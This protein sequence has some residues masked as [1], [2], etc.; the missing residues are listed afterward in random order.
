MLRVRVLGD[1]ELEVDGRPVEPPPSRRARAL[2]GYLAL[3]PGTHPRSVLAARFWPDVLDESARTSLRGALTALRR[4][5]GPAA[6]AH[7][8]ATREAAG[9]ADVWTDAAAFAALVA[10]GRDAEA[11]ALCRGELLAG[12]DDD[13]VLAARDQHR[14]AQ[15]AALARL[16]EAAGDP[17]EALRHARAR[18]ALDPLSEE[19]HR[20]LMA[21]LAASGDRAAALAAYNRLAE[22]LRTELR[23]A[24]SAATREAAE[25][26]RRAEADRPPFPGAVDPTGARSPF[27]GRREPLDRLRAAVASGDRHLLAVSG[28]PGI[29]KT[30]LL[31][32]LARGAYAD[33]AAV[34]YGRCPEEPVAPYQAFAEAL[35]PLAAAEPGIAPL[36]GEGG[37]EP[38]DAAGARLRLFEA[39]AAA[40][41]GTPGPVLLALDDLHWADRPS[42][43]LLSHLLRDPRPARLVV[44]GTYRESELGRGHPLARALADLRRDRLVDRVALGGLDDA[45]A[46]RLIEAWVGA[47]ATADLVTAVH[48]ETGGN[49][50][51]IE[52]VLRHLL[53]CGAVEGGH[54]TRS[55]SELGVPESVREVIGRRLDRLGGEAVEV[56][57]TAAVVGPEFELA[58]LERAGP[59]RE[60]VL[61]ALERAADANLIRDGAASWSFTHALIREALHGGL[62][63]L[64]RA[65]L[66]ARVAEALAELG[67]DPGRLAHHGLEAAG[68]IG[69]ERAA[70]WAAAAGDGAL[71]ALAYEEA[72]EHY[73]D[74]LQILDVGPAGVAPARGDAVAR[75]R[76]ELALALADALTRSGDPA[77]GEACDAAVAAARGDAELLGRAALVACGVGVTIVGLDH[78]RIALLEDALRGDVTTSLRARLLARLAIALYYAPGRTRSG[79]LSAQAVAV[80]REAGDPDALLAAL[81]ARH[82]GLWH[83]HGLEERFR[84]AD[85]MIALA[86]AHGRREA[87]LQGRNWRCVDL[88]EAGDHA[89]FVAEVAEHERLADD[90]RLPAFRW[91]AGMWRA[92]LAARA[93]RR[94][95]ALELAAAA[96]RAGELAGDPNGELFHEMV[97][98]QLQIQAG[99]YSGEFIERAERRLREYAAGDAWA[100]GLVWVYLERGETEKA[101]RL[102]ERLVTEELMPDANWLVSMVDYAHVTAILGDADRAAA[103]YEEL[104]PFAGRRIA[105]GRAVYDHG[106]VDYA[107]ALF[108][109]TAGRPA[110]AVAHF[111]AALAADEALGARP[112]LVHTQVAFA[113]LL[114]QLG[115]TERAREVAAAAI[116]GAEA[117]DIPAVVAR[118]KEG[119][120]L[121]RAGRPP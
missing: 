80:A 85:E 18:V 50:F 73:R 35:R 72:A 70:G 121:R 90:L 16:A 11:L 2:L 9:L 25:A 36:L 23:V 74:A 114:A 38:G 20:D 39:V 78:P 47:E 109:T 71:T 101:T 56:L 92:A 93:G 69:A 19:A 75:L 29:G 37:P 117:L 66:H 8:V 26:L 27:A 14:D 98:Y 87:E 53:E 10:E 84:V 1:L 58:V 86:Q 91:Y 62:S 51:F 32:E 12:L 103:F 21:R 100:P 4:A 3:Q 15:A 102:Y 61:D 52:E 112:W 77:A 64:R 34:L 55:V 119:A 57:E 30:R 24:P 113:E 22:R 59:S 111:E 67:A 7:L 83:P 95:E 41:A 43:L 81:N 108:A 63:V 48:D 107:L 31:A 5:I 96:G 13:W 68:L 28:D 76:S 42:L 106:S 49:P 45:A 40:L 116:A 115:Q 17:E 65:R 88:W 54:L 105:A 46:G 94:E 97:R 6:D 120:S 99:E 79:E 60:A 104:L 33:G 110:D 82:V 118:I 44:V 89:G